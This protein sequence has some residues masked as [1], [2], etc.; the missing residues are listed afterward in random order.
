MLESFLYI[1]ILLTLYLYIKELLEQRNKAQFD[2]L[3][4][5][6]LDD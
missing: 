4:E 5:R 3:S 6:I 1:T 2:I